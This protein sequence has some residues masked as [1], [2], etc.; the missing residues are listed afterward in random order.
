METNDKLTILN[1]LFLNSQQLSLKLK[2]NA[3]QYSMSVDKGFRLLQTTTG[4]TYI[5]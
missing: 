3:M 1:E 4:G 5:Y 2:L